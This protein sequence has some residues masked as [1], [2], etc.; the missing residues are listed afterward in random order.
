MTNRT[1]KSRFWMAHVDAQAESGLNRAEYCRHHKL[2]YHTL[3]YWQ[4]KGRR[5]DISRPPQLIPVPQKITQTALSAKPLWGYPHVN[6]P[7]EG[8]F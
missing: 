4:R 3:T 2:S 7:F 6:T 8:T 1:H 5:S